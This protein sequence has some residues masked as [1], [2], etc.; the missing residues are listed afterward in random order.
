M[1]ATRKMQEL[2]YTAICSKTMGAGEDGGRRGGAMEARPALG[3]SSACGRT[4]TADDWGRLGH[5]LTW[6]L[7]SGQQP[8]PGVG[9]HAGARGDRKAP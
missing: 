3:T 9:A 7:D 2:R 8:E 1:E 5:W 6:R 4:P